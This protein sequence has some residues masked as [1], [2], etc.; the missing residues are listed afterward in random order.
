MF[1]SNL[2]GSVTTHIYYIIDEH[3]NLFSDQLAV[4]AL[5]VVFI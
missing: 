5:N 3:E 2:F 4:Y 1:P